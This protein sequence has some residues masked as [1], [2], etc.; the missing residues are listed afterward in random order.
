M[1]EQ[2]NEYFVSQYFATWIKKAG[3]AKWSC[4]SPPTNVARFQFPDSS[5]ARYVGLI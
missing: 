1:K 3:L 2:V 4:H 5:S